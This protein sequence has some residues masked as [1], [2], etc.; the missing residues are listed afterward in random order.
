MIKE[1]KLPIEI[2]RKIFI[3]RTLVQMFADGAL[4]K[5]KYPELYAS[6]MAEFDAQLSYM[7]SEAEARDFVKKIYDKEPKQFPF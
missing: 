4:L 6:I 1:E 2:Q 3:T 7:R 5:T